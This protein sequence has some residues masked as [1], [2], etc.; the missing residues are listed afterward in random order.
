VRYYTD[1]DGRT[2]V[3]V[4]VGWGDRVLRCREGVSTAQVRDAIVGLS[5]VNGGPDAAAM[6]GTQ[7]V[8]RLYDAG[9][10]E[11]G[12]RDERDEPHPLGEDVTV[13]TDYT[14]RT[15]VVVRAST[16]DLTIQCAPGV[17][18]PQAHAALIGLATL[19]GSPSVGTARL[20]QVREHLRAA[21]LLGTQT[22]AT[23][24]S[25]TAPSP[26][27]SF[28]A[29]EELVKAGLFL[30]LVALVSPALYCM[31]SYEP[32]PERERE[33]QHQLAED[34]LERARYEQETRAIREN[35]YRPQDEPVDNT[36]RQPTEE[37]QRPEPQPRGQEGIPPVRVLD[38]GSWKQEPGR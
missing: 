16:G 31:M 9:F 35:I 7:V 28:F 30:I 20:V 15:V 11:P 8:N 18:V 27:K 34:A 13:A 38:E 33:R 36:I 12:E 2:V 21:G 19:S 37:S 6:L 14:G 29:P 10:L 23:V 32:G 4:R 26:A 22:P 1:H 17:T 3:E 25:P 5:V 24:A